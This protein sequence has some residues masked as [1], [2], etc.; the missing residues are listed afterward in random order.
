MLEHRIQVCFWSSTLYGR[1]SSLRKAFYTIKKPFQSSVLTALFWVLYLLV[2]PPLPGSIQGHLVLSLESSEA[3]FR[4]LN[5][6]KLEELGFGLLVFIFILA[7]DLN[8]V[9]AFPKHVLES[10]NV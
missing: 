3:T 2:D 6:E 10:Q 5:R 7:R 4:S 9:G 1:V 8:K